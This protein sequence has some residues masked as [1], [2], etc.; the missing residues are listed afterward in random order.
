MMMGNEKDKNANKRSMIE[1]REGK[2][3]G[4]VHRLYEKMCNFVGK[5][6]TNTTNLI[7]IF[8]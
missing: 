7:I 5:Y 4:M 1:E 2:N 3:M 6:L 8:T